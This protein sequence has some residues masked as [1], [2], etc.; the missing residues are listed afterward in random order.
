MHQKTQ[1]VVKWVY[2]FISGKKIL[3]VSQS[4]LTGRTYKLSLVD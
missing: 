3:K 4:C 1:N 2:W